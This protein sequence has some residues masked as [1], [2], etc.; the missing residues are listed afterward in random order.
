MRGKKEMKKR[1]FTIVL[2]ALCFASANAQYFKFEQF[3]NVEDDKVEEESERSIGKDLSNKKE[4]ILKKIGAACYVEE[5]DNVKTGLYVEGAAKSGKKKN[6]PVKRVILVDTK[7][8]KN[9]FEKC[10]E[11]HTQVAA[12]VEASGMSKTFTKDIA[13]V[14]G[15]TAYIDDNTEITSDIVNDCTVRFSFVEDSLGRV[16][17][18][19]GLKITCVEKAAGVNTT[20]TLMNDRIDSEDFHKEYKASFTVMNRRIANFPSADFISQAKEE[21]TANTRT[22]TEIVE[23]QKKLRNIEDLL[24]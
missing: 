23:A 24:Q 2:A 17:T 4:I 15:Y 11:W 5:N 22:S 13:T 19:Y 12:L 21:K 7:D 14:G 18:N 3:Y 10:A 9:A 20:V 16:K 1:L 6:V 8:L